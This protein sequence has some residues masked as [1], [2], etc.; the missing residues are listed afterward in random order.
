[1]PPGGTASEGAVTGSERPTI[2]FLLRMIMH[3]W[4]DAQAQ[5]I[6]AHLRASVMSNGAA[7]VQVKLVVVDTIL[8][9]ACRPYASRTEADRDVTLVP[10][11]KEHELLAPEPLLANWGAANGLSYKFDL[12]VRQLLSTASSRQ[13]YFVIPSHLPTPSM[14]LSLLTIHAA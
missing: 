10:S 6:L 9:Y 2:V 11:V 12:Q 1:M 7:G 14:R 3:N 4:A 13:L 8:G 5:E